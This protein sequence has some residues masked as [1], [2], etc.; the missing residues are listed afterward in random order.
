MT[1]HRHAASFGVVLQGN[2]ELVIEGEPQVFRPGDVYRVPEGA[3]HFARQSA[4]Y[5]DIVIFNEPG[6][7]P[8]VNS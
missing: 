8:I 6:P 1:P 5:K 7:V 2:C 4:D 3:L